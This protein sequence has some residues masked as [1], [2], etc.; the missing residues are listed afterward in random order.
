[1]ATHTSSVAASLMK[2]GFLTRR[3]AERPPP[4]FFDFADDVW[5][6]VNEHFAEEQV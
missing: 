5:Q 1:M 2:K 6:L 4:Y 3:T